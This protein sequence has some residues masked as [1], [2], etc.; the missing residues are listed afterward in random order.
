MSIVRKMSVDMFTP[1][2]HAVL[3]AWF[4]RKPPACAKGIGVG[5]AAARLGFRRKANN[6]RRID[7]AAAFI[8]LDAGFDKFRHKPGIA[9]RSVVLVPKELFM[10]DWYCGWTFPYSY[11]ATWVPQYD[12]FVVTM[13]GN[14]EAFG[15]EDIALGSFGKKTPIEKGAKKIICADWKYQSDRWGQE[16]WGLFEG[17][18]ISKAEGEAWADE[19]WPREIYDEDEE[20]D[21]TAGRTGRSAPAASQS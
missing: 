2:E 18:L 21:D 7:A 4:R 3:S 5:D 15:Y 1:D 19:V 6:Y 20:E 12:R 16:K 11:R 17:Q 14:C 10:I 13:S 9:K 8:V